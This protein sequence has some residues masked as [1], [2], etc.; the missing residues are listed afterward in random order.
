L[1]GEGSY[2]LVDKIVTALENVLEEWME[3]QVISG[4]ERGIV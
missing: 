4:V 1:L 3:A 2:P